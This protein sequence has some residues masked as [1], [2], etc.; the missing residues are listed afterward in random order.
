MDELPGLV[1][2]EEVG[3]WW[4]VPGTVLRRAARDVN[5][6]TQRAA[7]PSIRRHFRSRDGPK[8]V[9]RLRGNGGACSSCC[10]VG[11]PR[12]EA[13]RSAVR[14]STRARPSA[15]AA[16]RLAWMDGSTSGTIASPATGGS[17]SS[18]SLSEF[19]SMSVT[20]CSEAS[21]SSPSSA[22]WS[23]PF[24]CTLTRTFVPDVLVAIAS[25]S[26]TCSFTTCWRCCAASSRKG[27]LVGSMAAFVG[28]SLPEPPGPEI[29]SAH[30]GSVSWSIMEV[31]GSSLA[32]AGASPRAAVWSTVLCPVRCALGA[33]SFALAARMSWSWAAVGCPPA[34]QPLESIRPRNHP[35]TYPGSSPF[36]RVGSR[37]CSLGTASATAVARALRE[38]G[39]CQGQSLVFC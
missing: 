5:S 32:A 25:R 3:L 12:R 11:S 18:A 19:V 28:V 15:R 24:D 16:S 2:N 31:W 27:G 14:A 33:T 13:T 17:A 4:R 9:G 29:M 38:R 39:P 7:N 10:F 35:F 21:F 8:V 20:D 30:E 6:R 1:K 34:L 26:S 22:A 23:R 37:A 36:L